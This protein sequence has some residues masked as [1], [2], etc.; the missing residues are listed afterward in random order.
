MGFWDFFCDYSNFFS[1]QMNFFATIWLIYL[2]LCY[3]F[4][5]SCEFRLFPMTLWYFFEFL[6]FWL[7]DFFIV[8]DLCCAICNFSFV[9]D[10]LNFYNL[11]QFFKENFHR[12]I[13]VWMFDLFVDFLTLTL[14]FL[15]VFSSTSWFLVRLFWIVFDFFQ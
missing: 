4:D 13:I 3:H 9:F 2:D 6:T 12:L 7:F 14:T 5:F 10:H 1:D 15:Y 11:Y 8:F